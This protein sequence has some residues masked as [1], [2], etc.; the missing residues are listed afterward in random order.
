MRWG[1]M[2]PRDSGSFWLDKQHLCRQWGEAACTQ[3]T[4]VPFGEGLSIGLCCSQCVPIKF[5]LCSP[6]P[7]PNVFLDIGPHFI[8]CLTC[9]QCNQPKGRDYKIS[10]FRLCKGKHDYL[11][12][13][14][15]SMLG[16]PMLKKHQSVWLL[17]WKKKKKLQVPPLTKARFR[18]FATKQNRDTM[19]PGTHYL[20]QNVQ[21]YH[22]TRHSLFATKQ[23]YLWFFFVDICLFA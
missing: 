8:R 18:L 23:R 19:W 6:S 1:S 22:A 21:T 13:I 7:V 20:L 12:H 15:A 3:G 9:N 10:I 5:P 11:K 16:N 17:V 2:H 14:W 4:R